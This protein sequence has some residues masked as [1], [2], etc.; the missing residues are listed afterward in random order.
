MHDKHQLSPRA[1]SVAYI[2]S[3]SPKAAF[4][5]HLVPFGSYYVFHLCPSSVIGRHLL[6]L[7]YPRPPYPEALVRNVLVAA[8]APVEGAHGRRKQHLVTEDS[9]LLERGAGEWGA[10][11]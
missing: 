11:L 9:G 1:L 2:V 6:S 3:A 5:T 4:S 10:Y 8:A 7:G